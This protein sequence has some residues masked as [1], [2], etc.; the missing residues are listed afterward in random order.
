MK[1]L[2]AA[3]VLLLMVI[4]MAALAAS[5]TDQTSSTVQSDDVGEGLIQKIT[6]N[7]IVVNDTAMVF[8]DSIQVRSENGDTIPRSRLHVG[9]KVFYHADSKRVILFIGKFDRK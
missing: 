4:P 7:E 2:C 9:D 1:R 8:P 3:L 5:S 6:E